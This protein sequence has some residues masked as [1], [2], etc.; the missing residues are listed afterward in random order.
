MK[1][2][3]LLILLFIGVAASAQSPDKMSY[4]AVLRDANGVILKNQNISIQFSVLQTSISGTSVYQEDHKLTTNSNGLVSVHI[5]TGTVSAGDFST[6]DWSKGPYF[7]QS[8]IDPAGGTNYAIS[9]TTEFVSVP[10]AMYASKAKFADSLIGGLNFVDLTTNQTVDGKKTFSRD[11]TVNGISLGRGRSGDSTNT[12]IGSYA[13]SS[14]TISYGGNNT[15]NGFRALTSNTAGRGNT[16]I[17]SYALSSN[18]KGLNNTAIGYPALYSNTTGVGNTA[19]GYYALRSN[20]TGWSN[21]AN[22]SSD[23]YSNTTGV[24]NTAIGSSAL[25]S[26]T[27]GGGNTANGFEVLNFNTTGNFNTANGY[28]SLYSNTTGGAN[29]SNGNRALYYNTTG[30]G[31]TANGYEALYN[32]DDGSYNTA[33]GFRAL[34]STK[35]DTFSVWIGNNTAN[36]SYALFSN[37]NGYDNTA[38]GSSA[39]YSN[40][41]GYRNTSAG[42]Y[43]LY[44]NTTGNSNAANGY[45]ALYSNTTG[46]HNTANGSY[47]LY[48]NTTGGGNTAFGY[49][50]GVSLKNLSNST[51]I[52]HYATVSSNN[53]VR[54]G[55]SSISRIGGQ[56]AWTNLS[57]GRIKENVK[58]AVPG[59]SFISE[60]R[61]VTYTINTRKQDEITMQAMPDSIK[62]VRM[63]SD[64]EYLK[65]SSIVRTG[66]IAQEVE[67]AARKVGFD[68]DGV[69]APENETDLYGIRYAEFVVPLVKAVQEQQEMIESQQEMIEQLLNRIATLEKD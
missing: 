62:E 44:S 6:I 20:T 52:G 36:G 66:F 23:L 26:N 59:I 25:R 14:N 16:A 13:L 11:L 60:L 21:T 24:G 35:F 58:E 45:E 28:F 15:A 8:E 65:S 40:T 7:L 5:G 4:Q 48:F 33:N 47:A 61:P 50:A 32:N 17:G 37:S 19:I 57:D 41:T 63:L 53:R 42:S 49:S 56:V 10:Y 46:Y 34:Y 64:E 55:N 18:T 22:G 51:A 12:A 68:F 29:T 54:I 69:S 27:T 9:S 3:Y 2:I 30:E 39:L 67:E 38:T 1:N 31:N 43:A